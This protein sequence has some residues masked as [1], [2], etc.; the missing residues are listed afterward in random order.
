MSYVI[1]LHA[2]QPNY[3]SNLHVMLYF[4]R[5]NNSIPLYK[6]QSHQANQVLI[7]FF[8]NVL[9]DFAS[10]THV[11]FDTKLEVLITYFVENLRTE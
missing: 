1:C 2:H 11:P 6:E 4:V 3:Y 10:R 8:C 9:I 7:Y 5:Y